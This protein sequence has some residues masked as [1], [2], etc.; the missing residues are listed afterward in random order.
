MEAAVAVESG[1]I[2][3]GQVPGWLADRAMKDASDNLKQ[4][5]QDARSGVEVQEE[6]ESYRKQLSDASDSLN[7]WFSVA[8]LADDPVDAILIF[9]KR[10]ASGIWPDDILYASTRAK[11]AKRPHEDFID[12]KK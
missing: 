5:E 11:Y 3:V 12:D 6:Q 10:L 4:L 9:W 7:E 2:T 8:E 1:D